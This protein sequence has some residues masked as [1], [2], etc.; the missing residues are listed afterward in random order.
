M[1]TVKIINSLN[2]CLQDFFN[3][4]SVIILIADFC[5]IKFD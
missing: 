1:G 4:N 3:F 2:R 5:K